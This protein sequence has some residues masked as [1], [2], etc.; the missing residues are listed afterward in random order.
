MNIKE[1]IESLYL[2]NTNYSEPIQ[3]INQAESLKSLSTDLYIDAKR[4]VPH[5]PSHQYPGQAVVC[6]MYLE[7]GVRAVE[8]GSVMFGKNEW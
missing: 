7:G 5:I 3:A 6:E 4:F 8:I 2:T 1:T